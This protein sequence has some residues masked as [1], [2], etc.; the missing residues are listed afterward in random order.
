MDDTE[1][2][3][4]QTTDV[5]AV[6]HDD[7]LNVVL[8]VIKLNTCWLVMHSN[9]WKG[10]SHYWRP[11]NSETACWKYFCQHYTWFSFRQM[12]NC[13]LPQLCSVLPF[14]LFLSML[15]CI[16]RAGSAL[17]RLQA[18]LLV[19]P[20][21]DLRCPVDMMGCKSVEE[22]DVNRAQCADVEAW[23]E[24]HGV[25]HPARIYSWEMRSAR[26]TG[27]LTHVTMPPTACRIRNTCVF[28]VYGELRI[29]LIEHIYLMESATQ[30]WK[31]HNYEPFWG[32]REASTHSP[33]S[34]CLNFDVFELGGNPIFHFLIALYRWLL[35][36]TYQLSCENSYL[37]CVMRPFAS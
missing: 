36:I 10:T 15:A 25:I 27:G 19:L 7:N 2:L 17:C 26:V 22:T 32:T 9:A 8:R 5:C 3:Y 21:C 14:T 30:A 20:H 33:R 12:V 31:K 28:L 16:D 18:M 34:W 6:C 11:T 4:Q 24:I 35:G 1:C 37:A 13:I 23:R 29:T